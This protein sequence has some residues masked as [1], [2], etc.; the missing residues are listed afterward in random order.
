MLGTL[1]GLVGMM[2][3]MR[4]ISRQLAQ[5]QPSTGLSISLARPGALVFGTAAAVMLLIGV[6]SGSLSVLSVRDTTSAALLKESQGVL[7]QRRA[8]R[9][10]NIVLGALSA[11]SVVMVLLAMLLVATVKNLQHQS[12]GFDPT[13]LNVFSL[14][15]HSVG[16][17][18]AALIALYEDTATRLKS[19]SGITGVSIASSSLSSTTEL[20][21]PLSV[22]G[23]TD[24]TAATPVIIDLVG[25]DY[26]QTMRIPVLHGSGLESNA[27][28][29]GP[30]RVVINS[31]LLRILPPDRVS[32]GSLLTLGGT[33]YVLS[34]VVGDVKEGNLRKAPLPRAYVPL[35]SQRGF[36]AALPDGVTFGVRSAML[37]STLTSEVRG[38]IRQVDAKLPTVT[39]R[40]ETEEIEAVLAP[41]HL[42]AKLSLLFTIVTLTLTGLSIYAVQATVVAERTSEFGVRLACGSTRTA[43]LT[44][45]LTR[46]LLVALPGIALGMLGGLPCL[47]GYPPY[48]SEYIQRICYRVSPHF[49]LSR[50]L[51]LS[52]QSFPRYTVRRSV[53]LTPFGNIRGV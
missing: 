49:C 24:L 36:L 19:L 6:G 4:L 31:S 40:T 33:E 53:P 1:V 14:D 48:G 23:V 28:T 43:L 26:F 30:N 9:F 34:G 52:A 25:D 32:V 27:A 17:K 18:G 21:L 41:E 12:L 29:A 42:L 8:W 2:A 16:Y 10:R 44:S 35:S 38:I 3:S 37:S 11:I 15:A 46:S 22:V 5:L 13:H 39:L 50:H 7:G 20:A 47:T 45:V 51:R